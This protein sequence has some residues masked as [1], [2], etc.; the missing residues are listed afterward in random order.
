[1]KAVFRRGSRQINSWIPLESFPLRELLLT[2][3]WFV[4]QFGILSVGG[5]ALWAR[6]FDRPG[7]V[8]YI[9]CLVTMAG[10][11]GGFHW[12]T[13]AGSLWLTVPFAISAMLIPVVTFHFF[14]LYPDRSPGSAP[15]PG[16]RSSESTSS[17]YWRRGPGGARL[18]GQCQ[19]LTGGQPERALRHGL[20]YL[21]HFIHWCLAIAAV[22]FGLTLSVLA[23]SF[24]ANR[25]PIQQ[26]HVKW[27]L[28]AALAATVPVGYT[29][30]LARF[31]KR[32][33]RAWGGDRAHVRRQSV[34]H[35][36]IRGRDPAA[37]TPRDRRGGRSRCLVLCGQSAV[38]TVV[39]VGKVSSCLLGLYQ[40][41]RLPQQIPMVVT[42]VVASVMLLSLVRRPVAA[43]DRPAV[44]PRPVSTG[45]GR[46]TAGADRDESGKSR[47]DGPA[48]AF[49]LSGIAG[50]RSRRAL[51]ARGGRRGVSPDGGRESR[52]GAVAIRRAIRNFWN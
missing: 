46:A 10:F 31:A 2:F 47:D 27:I 50:R 4:L 35:G 20:A 6:P 33:V 17:P 11:V 45:P 21:V 8:F 16:G 39:T 38:T 3:V 15:A 13:I 30:Y 26:Q 52:S 23:D 19:P 41:N 37:Q 12:W 9:M 48:S 34:V 18:V 25:N 40:Q 24:F 44:L 29:L 14:C 42:I 28:W 49:V 36:G 5:L 1:M 51:P 43:D 22:Y 32:R 7:R